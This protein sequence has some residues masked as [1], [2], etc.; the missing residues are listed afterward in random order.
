M[1]TA[2]KKS[3]AI[4]RVIKRSLDIIFSLIGMIFLIPVTLIV[5]MIIKLQDGGPVF[6]K[7]V[8]T[9]KKGKD[10]KLIKFRSMPVDNDV[11]NFDKEDQ[12]TKFG[13]YIRKASID[14]LP[15]CWNIL[16]GEMSFI[17]PRPWIPE[18]YHNMSET[19]R[20]RFIVR[21]GI[22]GLA[23]V[24]GRNGISVTKKIQ[25]DLKYIDNFSIIEDIKIVFLT[26]GTI[27]KKETACGN[28]RTVREEI[29][30]LK[31]TPKE[32]A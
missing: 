15:Q 26:I 8:R 10:F 25:Y 14:E 32:Q 18:Y 3:H 20:R 2:R 21:P 22:T 19:Q 16:K 27:F 29:S 31:D 13:S 9:G 11:R 7:Q 6:F 12:M 17:G 30:E 4:Y 23:Q 1:T 5:G 24:K 28:K